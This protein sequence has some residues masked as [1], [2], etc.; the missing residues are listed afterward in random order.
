M[1]IEVESKPLFVTPSSQETGFHTV[2][3][4]A[5]FSERKFHKKRRKK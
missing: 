5:L 4:Q 2:P 1:D 3:I